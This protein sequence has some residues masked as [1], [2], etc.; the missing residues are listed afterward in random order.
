MGCDYYILKVIK[1]KYKDGSESRIELDRQRMYYCYDPPC[2][3]DDSD[4]DTCY[5]RYL[6]S[7]YNVPS[8][9]INIY[10]DEDF[11]NERIEEKYR[12]VVHR[13]LIDRKKTFD[14]VQTIDKTEVRER[15]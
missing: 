10:R 15:R 1:I 14:D 6:D 13:H 2:D 4:Y 5:D 11:K 7:I 8:P 12:Q 9:V 3:S